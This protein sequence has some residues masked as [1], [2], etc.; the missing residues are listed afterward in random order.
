M[1]WKVAVVLTLAVAPPF[2]LTAGAPQARRAGPMA[3]VEYPQAVS[4][5]RFSRAEIER[6]MA[7]ERRLAG[8]DAAERQRTWCAAAGAFANVHIKDL[9][10]RRRTATART[11]F[12]NGPLGGLVA[13]KRATMNLDALNMAWP[14]MWRC[15]PRGMRISVCFLA[16]DGN[17]EG[18]SL[19]LVLIRIWRGP[20]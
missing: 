18:Y 13:M 11:V 1:S 10:R 19:D 9:Q 17:L 20:P 15:P 12:P 4:G 14:H 6:I 3:V 8:R 5:A 7:V 2:P 16:N